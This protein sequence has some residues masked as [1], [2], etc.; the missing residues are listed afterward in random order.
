MGERRPS[1]ESLGSFGCEDE[2][3]RRADWDDFDDQEDEDNASKVHGGGRIVRQVPRRDG[4]LHMSLV[5][6]KRTGNPLELMKQVSE[7]LIKQDFKC[8][9]CADDITANLSKDKKKSKRSSW[10]KRH[11]TLRATAATPSHGS[12]LR[13][14]PAKRRSLANSCDACQLASF[15]SGITSFIPY[16]QWPRNFLT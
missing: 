2:F 3:E 6:E 1:S 14:F 15:T 10:K 11:L 12:A 5:L 13:V 4:G 7:G 16:V 9:M 8:A